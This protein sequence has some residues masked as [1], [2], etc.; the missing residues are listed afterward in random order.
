MV[1]GIAPCDV[2][3][4]RLFICLISSVHVKGFGLS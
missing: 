4:A 1:S 3:H 2:D